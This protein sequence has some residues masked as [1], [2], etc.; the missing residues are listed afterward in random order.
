MCRHGIQ[1][2]RDVLLEH[3]GDYRELFSGLGHGAK[4]QVDAL[5]KQAGLSIEDDLDALQAAPRVEPSDPQAITKMNEFAPTGAS[6]VPILTVHTTGDDAV[7]TSLESIYAEKVRTNGDAALRQEA[8]RGQVAEASQT[9][10]EAA[11]GR[12][13]LADHD[14]RRKTSHISRTDRLRRS[15]LTNTEE[16]RVGDQLRFLTRAGRHG[17]C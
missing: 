11:P 14:P 13:V 16:S 2:G 12:P 1:G 3:R 5:C 6:Q 10:S 15:R 8:R 17:G 4:A 7:F 9:L